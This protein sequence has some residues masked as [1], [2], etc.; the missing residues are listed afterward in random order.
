MERVFP[1]LVSHRDDLASGPWRVLEGTAQRGGASCNVTERILQVPFAASDEARVVR[2]HELTHARVSPRVEVLLAYVDE[3][4]ARILEC[5]EECRVNALLQRAAINTALLVDGSEYEGTRRTAAAGDWAEVVAFLF[6]VLG[7]GAERE[8]FRGV[9]KAQPT[10]SPPLREVRR[11]AMS[12]LAAAPTTTMASTTINEEGH[13]TGFVAV[14]LPLARLALRAGGA[15][16]PVSRDELRRFR[17]SLEPGARRPASGVFAPLVWLSLE[18]D[19]SRHPTPRWRREERCAT[20]G[21]DLRHPSRLLT[22]PQRRAFARRVRRGGGIV[23]VDQS[24]SMDIAAEDLDVLLRRATAPLIVGYSHQPGSMGRANAWRLSWG[25][26]AN[27]TTPVGNVGNGVDG[28]VLDW[29]TAQRRHREPIVWV[30]DGQVT[31]SNDHPNVA[32]ASY[33]ARRVRQHQIRLVRTL[34]DVSMA[35]NAPTWTN[36]WD[37][38]GRLG[39]VGS[40]KDS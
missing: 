35:L 38:F 31:D 10:W 36:K 13:P 16:V 8:Y 32:L 5:A 3:L 19:W 1:E 25:S 7:T 33:C 22:D 24:G 4:P 21:T 14:T 40:G 37:Q 15:Q 20:T 12:I 34:N 17:R 27:H 18:G 29:A 30:T 6:A 39:S 26:S 23:I 9:R 2:A 11:R 28:P